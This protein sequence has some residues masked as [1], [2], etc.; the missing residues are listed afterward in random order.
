MSTDLVL[1]PAAPDD[2]EAL[3][4][5]YWAAR[6]AA[7]PAMPRPVHTRGEVATWMRQVV[8]PTR[9]TIPMPAARETWVAERDGRSVGLMV[10]DRSWLDSLY[11]HP[12][13]LGRGIGSTLL[14]L[15]KSLRPGGFS[16]WVF[17]TNEAAQRFYA[18]HGLVAVRRTD[19]SENEEKAPD[20]EMAWWGE[21][22]MTAIRTRIDDLDRRMARLLAERVALT[23]AAQRVKEGTGSHGRDRQREAE[24]VARMAA[25]APELGEAG[26]ARI[27]DVVITV[28]LEAAGP[29]Y[30]ERG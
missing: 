12:D 11:V 19:G 18:R 26:I 22:P 21:Q 9:R 25:L 4:D 28:S 1:R 6:Q 20:L 14:A 27:M 17:E 5:L 24:I 2:A 30:P 16:L 8:D 15:A 7:F 10:L 3:A 29:P 23:G 13:L